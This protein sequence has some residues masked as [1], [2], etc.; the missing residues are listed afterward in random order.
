MVK[1]RVLDPARVRSTGKSFC[2]IPHRFLTDGFLQSLSRQELV[3]DCR[4]V[5]PTKCHD[6]LPSR[7][8]VKPG[9]V[10]PPGFV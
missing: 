7:A 3:V 5:I 8:R 6:I 4:A 2:F 10:T 1:K 9:S